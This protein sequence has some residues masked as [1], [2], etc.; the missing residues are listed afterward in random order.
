MANLIAPYALLAQQDQASQNL[1]AELQR[2][3]LSVTDL[4]DGFVYFDKATNRTWTLDAGG[5][6]VNYAGAPEGNNWASF[7]EWA[8]NNALWIGIGFTVATFGIAVLNT[9]RSR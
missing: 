1:A 3:G 4:P 8:G 5:N 9:R 6:L 2:E 7:T